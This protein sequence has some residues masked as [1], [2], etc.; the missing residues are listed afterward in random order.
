MDD[1]GGTKRRKL[2]ESPANDQSL[3]KYWTE[4]PRE[5]SPP[6]LETNGL[7]KV[8]IL[9]DWRERFQ[10]DSDELLGICDGART[11]P[12][13]VTAPVGKKESDSRSNRHKVPHSRLPKPRAQEKVVRRPKN[14]VKSSIVFTENKNNG[15]TQ[16]SETGSKCLPPKSEADTLTNT[17]A[18]ATMPNGHQ[19]SRKR[20]QPDATNQTEDHKVDDKPKRQRVLVSNSKRV[21]KETKAISDTNAAGKRTNTRSGKG[22]RK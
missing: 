9:K 12:Q 3:V 4:V 10:T 11:H 5:K 6:M 15:V 13:E 8:A 17:N 21:T 19:N 22:G 18:L 2:D 7:E 14:E 1:V 20:K 16:P